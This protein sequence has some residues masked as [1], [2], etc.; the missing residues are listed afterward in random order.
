MISNEWL[1]PEALFA[2]MCACLRKKSHRI[3][4]NVLSAIPSTIYAAEIKGKPSGSYS[5]DYRQQTTLS[6]ERTIPTD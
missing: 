6:E 5:V 1:D 4:A 2:N 3:T